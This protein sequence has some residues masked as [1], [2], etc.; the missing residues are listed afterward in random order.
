MRVGTKVLR[1]GVP[2]EDVALVP[3][4][5]LTTGF[6]FIPAVLQ[7]NENDEWFSAGPLAIGAAKY[8]MDVVGDS[9]GERS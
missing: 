1:N 9:E 7:T 4:L 8:M 2:V 6:P 3:N 5:P